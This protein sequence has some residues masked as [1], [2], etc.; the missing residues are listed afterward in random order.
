MFTAGMDGW[1]DGS[2]VHA[3]RLTVYAKSL[4]PRFL[5][6]GCEMEIYDVKEKKK[7]MRNETKREYK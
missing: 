2:F 3:P 6:G 5:F 7:V 1:M 4:P